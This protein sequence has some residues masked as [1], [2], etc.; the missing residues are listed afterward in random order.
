MD[1]KR[2]TSQEAVF[3]RLSA[4]VSERKLHDW[5]DWTKWCEGSCQDAAQLL[6][7]TSSTGHLPQD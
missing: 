2:M 5:P 1:G 4:S 6:G 7:G 3:W